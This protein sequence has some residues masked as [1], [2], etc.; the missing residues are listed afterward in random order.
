MAHKR[1][2]IAHIIPKY[3]N[4][5]LTLKQQTKQRDTTGKKGTLHISQ[6]LIMQAKTK[7]GGAK[8]CEC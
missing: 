4:E 7:Q 3:H 2:K 6:K 5:K 1:E 8:K